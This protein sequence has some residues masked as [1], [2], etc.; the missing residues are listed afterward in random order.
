MYNYLIIPTDS[1]VTLQIGSGKLQNRYEVTKRIEAIRILELIGIPLRSMDLS[2]S[3][4][5]LE[6]NLDNIVNKTVNVKELD[7][8]TTAKLNIHDLDVA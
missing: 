4:S 6:L 1:G 5:T 7:D 3:V 8:D 2:S